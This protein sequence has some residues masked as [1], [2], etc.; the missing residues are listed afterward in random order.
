MGRQ[1]KGRTW[2]ALHEKKKEKEK[3]RKSA[4]LDVR[5]RMR[6]SIQ[7]A[8][9][10]WRYLMAVIFGARHCMKDRGPDSRAHHSTRPVGLPEPGHAHQWLGGRAAL[11]GLPKRKAEI[12]D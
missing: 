4:E 12:G 9:A 8:A 5:L 10:R 6:R 1:A 3:N 7:L 11:A 2:L